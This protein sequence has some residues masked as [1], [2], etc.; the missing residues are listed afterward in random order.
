[1]PT[2]PFAELTKLG[3]QLGEYVQSQEGKDIS[4]TALQGVIADL[5]AGM[6]VLQ[7]PLRDLVSR[8]DFYTLLPH[9]RAG[10]G[11][12]QRDALIQDISRVYRPDVLAQVEEVLNG[13]LDASGGITTSVPKNQAPTQNM[14]ISGAF[15]PQPEP[16][17]SQSVPLRQLAKQT[18]DQNTQSRSPLDFGNIIGIVITVTI[19]GIFLFQASKRVVIPTDESRSQIERNKSN[20]PEEITLNEIADEIFWRRYPQLAGKK[21]TQSTGDLAREWT[22]I[23]QCEAIVDYRFYRLYPDMR[24]RL[25]QPHQ[26]EM[27]SAWQRLRNQVDGCS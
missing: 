17:S 20:Q 11:L 3:R 5:A 13:F 1:M 22:Q 2:P 23:R 9:A 24:G 8:Q 27:I 18:V 26:T 10:T 14:H 15:H 19:I 4:A 7:A 16:S 6:P 21:L 12:I 25:I